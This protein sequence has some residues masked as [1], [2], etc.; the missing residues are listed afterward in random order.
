MKIHDV[1]LPHMFFSFRE[2]AI[3]KNIIS[4]A[5]ED[6]EEGWYTLPRPAEWWPEDY[7]Y[8][9][10]NFAMPREDICQIEAYYLAM[11]PAADLPAL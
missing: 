1:Q 2:H 5:D 7:D 9:D 10:H 8:E 6:M 4:W 11:T 3:F